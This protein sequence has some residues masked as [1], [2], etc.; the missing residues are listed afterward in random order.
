MK[1]LSVL[2]F[3]FISFFC[4]SQINPGYSYYYQTDTC[5][6]DSTWNRLNIDTNNPNND[7]VIGSTNKPFFGQASSLPNAIMTDTTLAYSSSNLSYFEIGFSNQ[8]GSGFGYNMYLSFDHK[9]ETDTLIDGGYITVSHD[10]GQTWQNII[11]DSTCIMCS[12]NINS[13]NLYTTAD[14]LKNGQ[15]GFSGTSN[16]KTTIIQ[17]IWALPVRLGAQQISDSMIVRFNFISDSINTSKDG[18]IIDNFGIGMIDLGNAVDEYTNPLSVELYPNLT[19]DKFNYQTKNNET[20]DNI[21][22]L[23]ISGTSVLNIRQPKSADQIDISHLPAGNYLV[24]FTSKNNRL[25]KKLIKN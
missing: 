16:W 10:S 3:L 19:S 5:S 22:I 13:Q 15:F 21:I 8:D 11:F 14:S 12:P 25:I 18:W 2:C 24:Q 1:Y 23:N 6:F 9:Y 20:L 4:F 7:W 17:W